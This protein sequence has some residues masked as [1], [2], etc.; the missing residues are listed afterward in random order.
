MRKTQRASSTSIK[1]LVVTI[2]VPA[3]RWSI[4]SGFGEGRDALEEEDEEEEEWGYGT[5]LA[6]AMRSGDSEMLVK[7]GFIG[8]GKERVSYFISYSQ[9]SLKQ[10]RSY[11][12]STVLSSMHT[13]TM[14]GGSTQGEYIALY[15]KFNK[16]A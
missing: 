7:V 15:N 6:L 10:N 16:G 14:G 13:W 4:A 9:F 5:M 1:T 11:R 8:R 2:R 12:V 3:S